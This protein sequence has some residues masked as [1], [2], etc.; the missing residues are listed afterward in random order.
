MT[1][2]LTVKQEA[3]IHAYCTNG[4]NGTQAALTAGY[5]ENSAYAIAEQNLK[6][7][8]ISSAIA[9][10]RAQNAAKAQITVESLTEELEKDRK[11]A[12]DLDQPSA[13]VSATNSIA[14]LHG[15][16][17]EDRKNSRDPL[18]DAMARI[19]KRTEERKRLH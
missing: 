10:W 5:S 7:H 19:A 14:K 17:A 9:E 6:K 8:E 11:L 3:F 16:L 15:L 12:R 1:R 18:T 13:A 2:Q 4:G